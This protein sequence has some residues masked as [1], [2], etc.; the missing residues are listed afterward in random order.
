MEEVEEEQ[1]VL[2]LPPPSKKKETYRGH[3]SRTLQGIRQDRVFQKKME[4]ILLFLVGKSGN[5]GHV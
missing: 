1:E 4:A 2:F 3:S 5:L